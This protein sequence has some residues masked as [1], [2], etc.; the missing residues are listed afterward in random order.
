MFEGI[1]PHWQ[2]YALIPA[3]KTIGDD[4]NA[5]THP[6]HRQPEQATFE[7]TQTTEAVWA[8]ADGTESS[9]LSPK[10]CGPA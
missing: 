2:L 5:P 7:T 10:I 9:S 3:L 4:Q 6:P 1:S 8:L